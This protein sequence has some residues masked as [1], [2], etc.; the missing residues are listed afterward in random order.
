MQQLLC[1]VACM[2]ARLNPAVYGLNGKLDA[3]ILCPLC[4]AA[5]NHP[6][7]LVCVTQHACIP[8]EIHRGAYLRLVYTGS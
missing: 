3:A 4:I 6:D 2:P 5:L 7:C 1:F 8:D